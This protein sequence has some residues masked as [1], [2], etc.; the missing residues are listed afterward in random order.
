MR[1]LVLATAILSATF[2][3]AAVDINNASKEELMTLKGLGEKKADAVLTYRKENCFKN[4][5][6][7]SEVK[8]LGP[9][10]IENNKKELQAGKCQTAK[11]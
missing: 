2:L 5:E 9:K 3:F 4:I 6:E 1:L 8:G 7:L 10:F 11:K